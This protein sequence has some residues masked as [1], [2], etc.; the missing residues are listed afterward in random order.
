MP[1]SPTPHHPA[2]PAPAK[3]RPG[4][5]YRRFRRTV[6]ASFIVL[7]ILPLLAVVLTQG[8]VPKWLVK[9]SVRK[10]TGTDFDASWVSLKLDGRFIARDASLNAPPESG[11]T[12]DAARIAE[13]KR[14]EV[15]LDWSAWAAGVVAPTSV[16]V[17]DP[18]VRLSLDRGTHLLNV[19]KLNAPAS[20]ASSIAKVPRI[21]IVGGV[22]IVGEHGTVDGSGPGDFEELVRFDT[23]GWVSPIFGTK[24]YLVRFHAQNAADALMA[25]DANGEIDL[26]AV[27]GEIATS[28]IDLSRWLPRYIPS[29]SRELWEEL[30]LRGRITGSVIRYSTESGI[31]TTLT[32]DDVSLNAPIASGRQEITGSRNP[33]ME[34]VAGTLRVVAAGPAVGLHADLRGLFED[35][36]A[37]VRFDSRGL[38]LNS[39]YS[40]VVLARR[41]QLE[42]NPRILWFAPE[43]VHRNFEKFSGPTAVIDARIEISRKPPEVPEGD[44][45]G[46]TSI[47]GTLVF[48]KGTAA[49]EVFPYPMVDM[50]G[51]VRFDDDKVQ[52]VGI[53]G[54]GPTGAL[55]FAE[56]SID[57]P[58]ADSRYD[59]RVTASDVPIDD[60]LRA[61]LLASKGAGIV[62]AVFST[63]RLDELVAKGLVARPGVANSVP[64]APPDPPSFVPFTG[65]IDSIQV[66]VFSGFGSEQPVH[67]DIA[68]RFKQVHALP[69]AFP[70]PLIGTDVAVRITDDA[71]HIRGEKLTGLH[72]GN[73]A[74]EARIDIV[75]MGAAW[76]YRPTVRL[77]TEMFP[78][79][80]LL[81]NALPQQLGSAS[82]QKAPGD[83]FS[84]KSYL[85]ELHL[86]GPV[87]ADISVTPGAKPGDDPVASAAI[88]FDG[89][90][91][92]PDHKGTGRPIVMEN[93]V[94][95][96][97]YDPQGLAIDSLEGRLIPADVQPGEQGPPIATEFRIDG[98]WSLAPAALGAAVGGGQSN[99]NIVA[100]NLDSTLAAEDLLRPIVPGT[101]EEIVRLRAERNPEGRTDLKVDV[102]RSMIETADVR[103]AV[104]SVDV[105]ASNARNFQATLAGERVELLQD[106][107][108][109]GVTLTVPDRGIAP[110]PR[111]VF[112]EFAAQLRLNGQ[113]V[114]HATATGIVSFPE[115]ATPE[116]SARPMLVHE[117]LEVTLRGLLLESAVA[118]HLAGRFGGAAVTRQIETLKPEGILDG[119]LR[120]AQRETK[121][122]PADWSMWLAIRPRWLAVT[123][124]DEAAQAESEP[125]RRL[126]FPLISGQMTVEG[127][128]GQFDELTVVDDGWSARFNGRWNLTPSPEPAAPASWGVTGLLDFDSGGIPASLVAMLPR[129][130]GE[131]IDNAKLQVL[132]GIESRDTSVRIWS[133]GAPDEPISYAVVGK[134]DISGFFAYPGLTIDDASGRLTFSASRE[135]NAPGKASVALKQGV[136]RIAGLKVT[137]ASG[138]IDMAEAPLGDAGSTPAAPGRAIDV[139]TIT[140]EAY[141]GRIFITAHAQTPADAPA[142]YAGSLQL[143][144]IRFAD[145]LR[146]L[147]RNKPS[148]EGPRPPHTLSIKDDDLPPDGSRGLLEAQ[149]TLRGVTG[150]SAS[151]TG[152]GEVSIAGGNAVLDVPGLTTLLSIA[153]LQLPVSSPFDYAHADVHIE[154]DTLFFDRTAV[155]SDSLAILG[156][157]SMSTEDFAIDL[158]MA[159]RGRSRIPVLTDIFDAFRDELLTARIRGTPDKPELSFE[160][161]AAVR[162]AFGGSQNPLADA[163]HTDLDKLERD[164]QRTL[165]VAGV[166][167]PVAEHVTVIPAATPAP[168]EGP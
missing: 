161:F 19:A 144:G 76:D 137:S 1:S 116:R 126:L 143:A 92:R 106:S 131:G 168:A 136:M 152:R 70:Y 104:T 140:G 50:S 6:R 85:T 109:L 4:K 127:D 14:I 86:N 61:A 45:P 138:E 21:D 63:K 114:G 26:A 71:V 11:L 17:V 53:Q 83:A 62:D 155:L 110:P 129:A 66:H 122:D 3:A 36:P 163:I 24:R 141:G 48:E 60:V 112:K 67:Q 157:G 107:G 153:S 58:T 139:P 35:L 162:A 105:E 113:D 89:V 28:S 15:V 57:P 16:R 87:D 149:L 108:T 100:K 142:Q 30:R 115:E 96:I 118:R 80:P 64:P 158:R 124:G 31:D 32:L 93:L 146:D 130:V 7:M 29:H 75:Q 94:G 25:F 102:R 9:R 41:F 13:A 59:I 38:S 27:H 47:A 91:A 134:A 37:H 128:G 88:I 43:V 68:V 123:L 78:I 10:A 22:L 167:V 23:E 125:P 164:R 49:Y 72:G 77:H 2:G 103:G 120:L 81:I 145:I 40:A 121:A 166:G 54:R 8:P 46:E 119:E 95:A 34:G 33:R 44:V 79:E 73:A 52:I 56:G 160:N 147:Q 117:P 135:G 42:K 101:A 156:G 84:I 133:T 132:D 12:G 74:L 148:V 69:D 55:L 97:R 98:D 82:D 51:T 65:T 5:F 154:G 111:V 90:S 165:G 159:A 39:A 18:V 150:D 151:R 99:L 20:G